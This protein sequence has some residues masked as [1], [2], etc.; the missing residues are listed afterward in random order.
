MEQEKLQDIFNTVVQKCLEEGVDKYVVKTYRGDILSK[1]FPSCNDLVIAKIV[2]TWK[3]K[4][5]S[6]KI[7][8]Y[9][10]SPYKAVEKIKV[11]N[12]VGTNSKYKIL[13]FP[14]EKIYKISKPENKKTFYSLEK[15]RDFISK[16]R[17]L[18]KEER[19]YVFGL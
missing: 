1:T 14:T 9:S 12:S 13:Y 6:Y 8:D 10:S 7:R 5:L 15:A 11:A 4:K 19:D 16:N 3:D 17:K 18:P 2:L